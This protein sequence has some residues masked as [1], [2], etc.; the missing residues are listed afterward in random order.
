MIE[1]TLGIV[2]AIVDSH[3]RKLIVIYFVGASCTVFAR[4]TVAIIDILQIQ[5][6]VECCEFFLP[7]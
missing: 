6:N 7:I 4:I 3:T 1:L 5:I 2:L